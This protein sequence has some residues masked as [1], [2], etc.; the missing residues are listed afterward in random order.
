MY[1]VPV[2]PAAENDRLLH[3]RVLLHHQ[4]RVLLFLVAVAFIVALASIAALDPA[5]VP[6]VFGH[7]SSVPRLRNA[8]LGSIAFLRGEGPLGE[9][10]TS[11]ALAQDWSLHVVERNFL[12]ASLHAVW[13]PH[14]LKS[15]REGVFVDVVLII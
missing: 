3:A 10:P 13:L 6:R 12:Q 1:H 4:V 15:F 8:Y 14:G 9:F 11:D 5:S 7:P 2:H